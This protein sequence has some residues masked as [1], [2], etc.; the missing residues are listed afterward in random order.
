MPDALLLVLQLY[1][2]KLMEHRRFE[3]MAAAAGAAV[4]KL[5]EHKAALRHGL[6]P[7]G[8]GPGVAHALYPRTAI[9]YHDHRILL[10]R[11]EP[12]G[13]D[14]A[15]IEQRAVDGFHLHDFGGQ[16]V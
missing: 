4:V 6:V 10:P 13:L 16:D 11:R 15:R 5:P 14:H 3:T 12:G 9:H 2:A 1:L 7:S 8:S